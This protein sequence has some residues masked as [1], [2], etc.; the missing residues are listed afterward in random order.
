M[1]GGLLMKDIVAVGRVSAVYPEK[2]TAR[3]YRED[4]DNV[5]GELQILKRGEGEYAWM[6]A[7]GDHVVCLFLP[8]S[9]NGFILGEF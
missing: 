9:S 1:F 7:V 5:T 4:I 2:N 8:G 3:V 6:P